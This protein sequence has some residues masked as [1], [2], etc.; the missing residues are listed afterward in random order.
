MD[1]EKATSIWDLPHAVTPR[2]DDPTLGCTC[3]RDDKDKLHTK[4]VVRAETALARELMFRE[5]G[6]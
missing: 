2:Q 6:S 3:G 4:L 5:L 1:T